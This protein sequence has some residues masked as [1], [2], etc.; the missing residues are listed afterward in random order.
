[1]SLS[2]P[3]IISMAISATGIVAAGTADGRLWINFAGET[4]KE[5]KKNKKVWNGLDQ[6]KEHV[7][8]I[9]EGPI[10]AMSVNFFSRRYS[11]VNDLQGIHQHAYTS[12]LKPTGRDNTVSTCF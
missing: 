2:P 11:K 7:I 6:S 10:V 5:E 9:A 3:F 4:S 1:M 12:S 8:K